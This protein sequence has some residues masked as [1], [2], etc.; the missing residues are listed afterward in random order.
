MEE[1][2]VLGEL[3]SR[4]EA[5]GID[6]N[7]I[8]AFDQPWKTNEGGVGMYWGVF[9]ASRHAKFAWTG[10][11]SD[12]DHWTI[13]GFAVLLG[14]LVSLPV[15]GRRAATF[16]EAAALAIAANAVGAWLATVFAFWQTHYFVLGAAFALLLGITLLAPLVMITLARIEEIAV[17]AFCRGPRPLIADALSA[18]EAFAPKVSIHAPA[19]REPPEMLK[20]TLDA[21]ARIHYPNFER[22]VVINN[23]PDPAFWRPI[24]DHCRA[25]GERFKFINEDNLSGY[26]AGALRLAFS[27]T[28]ADAEIIGVIDADYVVR[29]DWLKDLVPGFADPKVGMVQAPQDHRDGDRTAMHHAMNGE[30]SAF[31]DIGMA[32]PTEAH[33]IILHAPTPLIPH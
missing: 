19:H 10:L 20:A 14:L 16:G 15:L 27:H 5:Y 2:V 32:H 18:P 6:Y 8:E 33:P 13:G 21:V 1:G 11:V 26:K 23:T 4:D 17:I 9:E 24:E 7:V 12:P 28:A 31:F 3:V 30:Y 29:P 22:I 25:L